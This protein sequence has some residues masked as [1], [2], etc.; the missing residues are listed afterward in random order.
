LTRERLAGY[1]RAMS[2][3]R[4]AALVAV[5]ALAVPGAAGA[6]PPR[7]D[8]VG[9]SGAIAF[10]V[11]LGDAASLAYV[12]DGKNFGTWLA[13]EAFDGTAPLTL[14]N[15]KATVTLR[16]A[17]RRL[18]VSFRDRT[19]VLR[20]ARGKAGLYRSETVDHGKRRL[21]GWVVFPQGRIV[22]GIGG[23]RFTGGANLSTT[24]LRSGSLLAAPVLAPSDPGPVVLDLDGDGIDVETTVTTNALTGQPVTSRWTRAGDDDVFVGL[25]VD[26][27]RT[28]GF[29]LS[30]P[31][32]TGTVLV[33]GGLRITRKN[34]TTTAV[35]GFQ[36][37]SALDVNGDG[38]LNP[39]DPAWDALRVYGDRN[40]NGQ[41]GDTPGLNG[42][43]MV[44]EMAAMNMQ[45][46]ALQQATQAESRRFQTLS[47]ASRA[48]HDVAMNAIKSFS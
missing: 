18:T 31:A 42:G 14:S 9:R 48:R 23:T 4:A 21:G 46:L 37:L 6:A 7:S 38:V 41:F 5:A 22:G 40:G 39:S 1:A 35:D 34:V 20:R 13:G 28:A 16:V 25:D 12:C 19:V 29:S 15:G 45:F 32:S 26:A 44:A 33:H 24:T 43:D 10:G 8:F 47:N 30:G 3:P 2:S 36:V 17:K 11:V 27:L